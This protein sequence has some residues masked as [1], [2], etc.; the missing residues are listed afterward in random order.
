MV[1]SATTVVLHPDEDAGG[2]RAVAQ[3]QAQIQAAGKVCRIRR[4][5][6]DSDPVDEWAAWL[7]ERAQSFERDCALHG[8]GALCAAWTLAVLN[9]RRSE[10]G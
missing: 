1:G 8:E 2:R 9:Y 7:A 6:P 5:P 4:C 3:A 10:H